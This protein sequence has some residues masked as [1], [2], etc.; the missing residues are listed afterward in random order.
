MIKT[1]E[2]LLSNK[3]G[4]LDR[5]VSVLSRIQVNVLYLHVEVTE[6]PRY[7]KI[8]ISFKENNPAEFELVIKQLQRQIDVLQIDSLTDN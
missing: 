2:A 1:I 4:V 8:Q 3:P 6:D 5:V 7:S